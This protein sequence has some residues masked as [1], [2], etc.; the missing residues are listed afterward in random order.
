V[1]WWAFKKAY[2][3]KRDGPSLRA[4]SDE[5]AVERIELVHQGIA[6]L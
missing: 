3:V 6:K 1:M 2:P 4:N 5:V